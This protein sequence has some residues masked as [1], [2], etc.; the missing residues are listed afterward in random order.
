MFTIPNVMLIYGLADPEDGVIALFFSHG[1][2]V[3][4]GNLSAS[5]FL[6]HQMVIRYT[7]VLSALIGYKGNLLYSLIVKLIFPFGIT[8]ISSIVW[9]RL[10]LSL[11]TCYEGKSI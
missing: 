4:M 8:I 7:G 5:A 1:W 9:D 11:K 3:W 10:R 2:I 6:I